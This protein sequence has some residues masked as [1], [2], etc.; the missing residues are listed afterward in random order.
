MPRTLRPAARRRRPVSVPIEPAPTISAV[1]PRRSRVPSAG[2]LP[3]ESLASEDPGGQREQEAEHG[4]GQTRV[5]HARRAREHHAVV[6]QHRPGELLHAGGDR[7]DPP[8]ARSSR[9]EVEERGPI[10]VPREDDLELA[11]VAL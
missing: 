3:G 1:V 2:Q 4:L 8:Q 6:G 10:E 11:E 9:D 5:V 7:L